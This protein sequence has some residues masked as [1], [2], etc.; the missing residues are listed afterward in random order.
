MGMGVG[1]ACPSMM[2]C[3]QILDPSRV[4]LEKQDNPQNRILEILLVS[5][6]VSTLLFTVDI[7]PVSLK[8]LLND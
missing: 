1:R 3:H 4:V 2:A 5:T 8:C 7:F 6:L